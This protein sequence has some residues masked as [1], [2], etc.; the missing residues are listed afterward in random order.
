MLISASV[1]IECSMHVHWH[2][3]V[4]AGYVSWHRILGHCAPGW[5]TTMIA[6]AY[7]PAICLQ[8]NVVQLTFVKYNFTYVSQFQAL[9]LQGEASYWFAGSIQTSVSPSW[10]YLSQENL[11]LSCLLSR[12]Q[13]GAMHA[14]PARLRSTRGPLC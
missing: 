11:H 4:G 7:K 6:A 3:H 5:H 12:F 2:A 14:C 8:G 9:G 1:E 13:P 10:Q